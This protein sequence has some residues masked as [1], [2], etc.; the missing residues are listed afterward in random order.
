MP[1]N[2]CIILAYL[3]SCITL[4]SLTMGLSL[5]L[6]VGPRSEGLETAISPTSKWLKVLCLFYLKP[7]IVCL[8]RRR[9]VCNTKLRIPGLFV[10]CATWDRCLLFRKE[11]L[12][13]QGRWYILQE[14]SFKLPQGPE[15]LSPGHL[16]MHQRWVGR[17]DQQ[18]WYLT[19][20]FTAPY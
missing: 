5:V 1:L 4:P 7:T 3:I 20:Y 12:W 19:G 17:Y 13:G 2:E 18:Y 11:P 9:T 10:G 6:G 16:S 14:E 15:E 8:Y